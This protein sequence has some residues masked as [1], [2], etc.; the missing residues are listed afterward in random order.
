MSAS[1]VTVL[2]VDTLKV[3]AGLGAGHGVAGV[4]VIGSVVLELLSLREFVN[5]I[6]DGSKVADSGDCKAPL[7]RVFEVPAVFLCDR[8]SEFSHMHSLLIRQRS[9]PGDFFDELRGNAWNSGCPFFNFGFDEPVEDPKH[10][11]NRIPSCLPISQGIR[12]AAR[13]R[14]AGASKRL[15][16]PLAAGWVPL[17]NFFASGSDAVSKRICSSILN[18]CWLIW[19]TFHRFEAE[20]GPV[21]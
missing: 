12:R 4:V 5:R 3:A 6:D 15:I 16:R 1:A 19:L 10:S 21:H 7:G 18:S 17:K 13:K 20:Q 9:C 8:R 14:L 2:L 11:Q